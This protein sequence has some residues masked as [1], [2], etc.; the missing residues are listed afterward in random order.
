MNKIQLINPPMDEGY[1]H[2]LRTGIYPPLNLGVIAS[3]IKKNVANYQIELFDGE[4]ESLESIKSKVN[5]DFVGINCNTLTY[6]TALEISI[7]AKNKG[8]TVFL[9]GP[10]ASIMAE[11]ILGNQSYIDCIVIGDGE[12]PI[13]MILDNMPYD[14]I[15]NLAYRKNGS[16][17]KNRIEKTNLSEMAIPDYCNLPLDKYF[18]NHRERYGHFKPFN[19]SLAIYSMKGCEWRDKTNGGCVFCMIPHYGVTHKKPS[20][21]WNEIVYFHELYGVDSFWEVSDSFV[22]NDEWLKEFRDSKPNGLDISLHIYG[23]ANNIN[24]E[25]AKLL[26]EIGVFEVFIGAESG[27]NQ[28]LR[29]TRKGITTNTTR[30]AIQALKSEGINVIVSFVLGLPGETR[31]SLARTVAFTKELASYGNINETS[32]SIMFPMPGSNAFKDLMNIEGMNEKYS[33]DIIDYE[34]L[35]RDWLKYFTNVSFEM[36]EEALGEIT[37]KFALNSTFSKPKEQILSALDC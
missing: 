4:I 13:K 25:K 29:N 33:S 22:D 20:H 37:S 27:D 8:A 31:E 15:P 7:I 5:A 1:S 16:I 28:I 17:V 18:S 19:S 23:R 6:K 11:E 24:P 34:E 9:G 10:Y 12:K 30:R 14:I 32:T 35:K 3:F 2:S 21:V 36:L 26:K